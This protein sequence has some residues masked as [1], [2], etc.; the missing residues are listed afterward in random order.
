MYAF[1]R[2]KVHT[3]SIDVLSLEHEG[4]NPD[5]DPVLQD[6]LAHLDMLFKTID[7]VVDKVFDGI[8]ERVL[9]EN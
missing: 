1:L 2:L 9:K 8:A 5:K 4:Y 3:S 7:E 6:W